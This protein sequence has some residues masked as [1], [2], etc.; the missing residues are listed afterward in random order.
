MFTLYSWNEREGRHVSSSSSYLSLLFFLSS[1][2]HISSFLFLILF[3]I[4]MSPYTEIQ[5]GEVLPS[6][7]ISRYA[8]GKSILFCYQILDC[9]GRMLYTSPW[10]S[11]L[12]RKHT[13]PNYF[14]IDSQILILKFSKFSKPNLSA[15]IAP[16]TRRLSSHFASLFHNLHN[17]HFI[18][19]IA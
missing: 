12:R 3:F 19:R 8:T 10:L 14:I 6:P 11:P 7:L 16:V 17:T 18:D 9:I 1:F 15:L 2:T 4:E 5:P 13:K